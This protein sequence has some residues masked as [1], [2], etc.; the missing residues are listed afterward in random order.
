MADPVLAAYGNAVKAKDALE[1]LL[2]DFDRGRN[3]SVAVQQRLVMMNKEFK[4]AVETFVSLGKGDTRWDRRVQAMQSDFEQIETLLNK[5]LGHLFQ[6]RQDEENREAL[7]GGRNASENDGQSLLKER[8]GIDD[9]TSMINDLIN[10]G[11][12]IVSGLG[13]NNNLIKGA[14]SKTLSVASALGV[15]HALLNVISGR[16]AQDRALVYGCCFFTFLVFCTLWYIFK[17]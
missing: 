1:S 7:F 12:S 5:Q 11:K 4:A 17:M 16:D 10:S 9:S 3:R 13:Q 8:R 6:R 2:E 14:H 15:S